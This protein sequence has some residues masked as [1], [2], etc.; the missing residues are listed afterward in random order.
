MPDENSTDARREADTTPDA[1]NDAPAIDLEELKRRAAKAEHYEREAI[2]RRLE[3]KQKEEALQAIERDRLQKA[4]EWQ[5]LAQQLQA[6]NSELSSYKERYEAIE[7]T[8]S[9]S[10]AQRIETIAEDMRSLVP[11]GLTPADTAK[12]LD[13]NLAKITRPTAPNIDAGVR[14]SG[15]GSAPVKLTP[16]EKAIADKMRI[17]YEDYAKYKGGPL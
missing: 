9:E 3:L 15:Q 14:S 2:E 7:A 10:N 5:D 17:S 12:W 16:E 8:L 1:G 11:T 4:G 13:Q 6:E